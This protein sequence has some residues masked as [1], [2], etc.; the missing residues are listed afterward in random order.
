MW[1]SSAFYIMTLFKCVDEI[2]KEKCR[3]KRRAGNFPGGPVV[4]TLHFQ[5]IRH[6]SDPWFGN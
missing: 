3:Q 2:N 5:F 1:E 4:K 6:R